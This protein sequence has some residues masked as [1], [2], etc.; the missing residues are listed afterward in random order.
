MQ[1]R[2]KRAPS[3]EKHHSWR[4]NVSWIVFLDNAKPVTLQQYYMLDKSQH[5]TL[6]EITQ[7]KM[8]GFLVRT[9]EI[10][11]TF[12][13]TSF[14]AAALQNEIVFVN[15]RKK[16]LFTHVKMAWGSFTAGDVYAL[17]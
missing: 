13:S 12:S 4:L 10:R 6:C 14:P 8:I 2:P 7:F 1:L 16:G 17:Q 15:G 5:R 9:Q 11:I 3:Q